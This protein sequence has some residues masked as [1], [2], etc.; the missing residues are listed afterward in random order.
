MTDFIRGQ[1][2]TVLS[3]GFVVGF[4]WPW[5]IDPNFSHI[6]AWVLWPYLCWLTLAPSCYHRWHSRVG[7]YRPYTR[8]GSKIQIQ[9]SITCLG[10]PVLNWDRH[11][12]CQTALCV[13]SLCVCMYLHSSVSNSANLML[14]FL[15]C[16]AGTCVRNRPGHSCLVHG[17]MALSEKSYWPAY[18]PSSTC[19][20]CNHTSET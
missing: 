10:L 6:L 20:D 9:V 3:V 18:S 12:M 15:A 17:R 4:T 1:S 19:L 8:Y 16:R 2:K 14:L 13:L 5:S 7:P 11:R